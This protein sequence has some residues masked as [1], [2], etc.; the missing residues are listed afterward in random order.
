MQKEANLFVNH[1]IF[2]YVA[3]VSELFLCI[4]FLTFLL[5]VNFKVTLFIIFFFIFISSFYVFFFKKKLKSIGIE[6]QKSDVDYLKYLN[7]SFYLIK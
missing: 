4:M 3:I 6:R 7:E 1:I 5:Y 2:S